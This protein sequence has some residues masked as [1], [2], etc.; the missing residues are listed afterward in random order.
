MIKSAPMILPTQVL[1]RTGGG[2]PMYRSIRPWRLFSLVFVLVLVPTLACAATWHVQQDGTGDF[3]TI[4]DAVAAAA[5]SDEVL[6]GPGLYPERLVIGITLTLRSTD[7][8][9][10]T[11]LDGE[12]SHNILQI[13]GAPGFRIE[14]L[15][16]RRGYHDSGGAIHICEGA[17]VTIENCIFR[18]NRSWHDAG[19]IYTCMAGTSAEV[20]DCH[21]EENHAAWNG[22]ACGVNTSSTMNFEGCLFDGNTCNSGCGGV[23]S[24]EGAH[25]D[26]TH[27][28]FV[29][30]RG[31]D[32]GALRMWGAPATISHCTFHANRAPSG[33]SVRIYDPSAVFSQNI[34]T[35]EQSGY[36]LV[37]YYPPGDHHCNLFF[38]NVMGA[39]GDGLLGANE[40]DADPR[41]CDYASD[42]FTLC[43]ISPA[44]PANND[45]GMLMGA[46]PE[47]CLDCGP[48]G[49]QTQS[50]GS[51]KDLYH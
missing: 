20:I 40:I 3:L 48:I 50:W 31:A 9:E 49:V 38:D 17:S 25:M 34:I 47:A 24:H 46:F 43:T 18:E 33:A 26:V 42:D 5:P 6:I 44:L 11:I 4:G 13:N 1:A 15:Q 19:A 22:G 16:F 28:L 23:A 12:D 2:H 41:Y 8:P 30:N 10:T 7:G 14:G 39:V 29:R 37:Y 51:L 35:S 45:C 36:G 21:F 27:C 32:A